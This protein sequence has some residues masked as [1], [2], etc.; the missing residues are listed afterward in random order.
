MQTVLD[1]LM[2]TTGVIKRERDMKMFGKQ[3][4][5]RGYYIVIPDEEGRWY[6]HHDGTV[7]EGVGAY[8][9]RPAFWETEA[10]AIAFFESWK[11]R[12]QGA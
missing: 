7:Q 11:A 5:S 2:A 4:P 3:R 8:T 12:H 6:L 1:T 10:D 9:E